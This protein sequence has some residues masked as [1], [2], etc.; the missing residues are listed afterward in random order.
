MKSMNRRC[1]ICGKPVHYEPGKRLSEFFPFC[2]ERCRMVDLGKWLTGE[3]AV[4]RPLTSAE[5][6]EELERRRSQ[7]TEGKEEA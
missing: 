6:V 7:E 3:Y 2:S 1:P 5:Q 4:S